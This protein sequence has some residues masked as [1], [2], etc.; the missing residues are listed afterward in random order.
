MIRN[1]LTIAFRN[2]WKNKGVATINIISLSLGLAC[3]ALLLLHV[4][5]EFSFDRFHA[6]KDHIFRVYRDTKAMNG[7][8]AEGDPYLPAPLGPAMHADLPEVVNYVRFCDWGD[9]FIRAPRQVNAM[10]VVFADPQVFDVFSFPLRYGDARTA[11]NEL[12]SVVLT[13]ETAQQLFGEENP[14]GKTLEIKIEDNFEPFT[15]TGVAENLPPNSSIRFG[16]LANFARHLASKWGK[17]SVDNWRRS[18]YF[19]YL[20]LKPGAGLATD[21]TR[22]QQF[23]D[24]YYPDQVTELRNKGYWKGSGAP[25]SYRLQ[26]LPSI[27]TDMSVLSGD[28]PPM[29]PKYGWILLGLAGLVL[30][31]AC[32][33]FTT[34]S[35]GRSAGRAREIGV[36]KVIGAHRRQLVGQFLAESLLL[37]VF[38]M[39]MAIGLA[40]ALLPALNELTDKKLRF[41]LGLYPELGWMLAGLTLLTGLLAGSYPALVLSGFRPVEALKSKFRIAGSNFFTKSLVTFQ[42]VL[43]VGLMACTLIMVRQ[44]N[45]LRTQNPGFDRENVL[46]VNASDTDTERIYPL[47]RTALAGRPEIAGIAASELALGA[48]SGWSRSG[49][50]YQ[51]QHKD[52]YEYFIDPDYIQVLGMQLI[53]GR[54]FDHAVTADTVTSVVIN[55]TMMRDFGWSPEN[56]LGQTL[57]GYTEG[58]GKDP[59]VIGVVRD[60]NFL[61]L[62][63]AVQPMMFHMFN[64]YSPFQFFVRLQPGD[65]SSNVAL[66]QKTWTDLVPD[67]PFR[68]KFLDENLGRFYAAE[69]R[70]SKIV[71]YSGTLAVLLACLGLLGLVALASLNRT[72]EIGIRKVLGASVAGITGLLAKDFLKLVLASF[73]IAF[74]VAYYLMEKWLSDFAYRIDIQWWMFAATGG[75]AI[76]IA[77]LTVSFQSV[78]AALANPVRSLRSE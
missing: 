37:S 5:D 67:L 43:S 57:T 1:Y 63:R 59:I 4:N 55:E 16:I 47:F 49:F 52:V 42:F 26:A 54:N 61:S 66:I 46:I 60:F 28:V 50:D 2:L 3:F 65:I 22:L 13:V 15:V 64:G 48:Q 76:A 20:E 24:K 29:N 31:I 71:G 45:Y 77:F 27:H 38:S 17:R 34:L 40:L 6:K 30:L 36:R 72:K 8:K 56:V 44:L 12:N 75:A 68:Y 58:R 9:N 14:T 23:Y 62:H 25:I 21:S 74:P 10:P 35:I 51:G 73:V 39:A 70:W 11:L 69:E 18:A 33:N 7:E 19:T 78:K 53:A 32:I 41:D